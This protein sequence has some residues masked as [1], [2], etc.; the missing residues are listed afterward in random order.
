MNW[1]KIHVFKRI[2]TGERKIFCGRMADI[3]SL[4]G[5]VS[6]RRSEYLV[7]G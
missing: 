6:S 5:K 3:R 7:G 2:F 1:V 4:L